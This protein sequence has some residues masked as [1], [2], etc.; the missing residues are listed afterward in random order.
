MNAKC[1]DMGDS[2]EVFGLYAGQKCSDME[3]DD[4]RVF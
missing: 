3:C 4:M 1:G 2:R